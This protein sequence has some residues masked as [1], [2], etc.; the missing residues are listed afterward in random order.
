M[1]T[2]QEFVTRLVTDLPEMGRLF[3]G[4]VTQDPLS[5][6]SAL[7]GAFFVIAASGALGYLAFGGV[8]DLLGAKSAR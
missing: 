4:V 7:V 1:A 5:A 3:E 8:L 2:L 6:I